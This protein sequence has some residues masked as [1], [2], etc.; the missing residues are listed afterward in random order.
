MKDFTLNDFHRFGLWTDPTALL[1][2]ENVQDGA[3]RLASHKT[4][5]IPGTT[6]VFVSFD[7]LQPIV[8][9]IYRVSQ[10]PVTL[11]EDETRM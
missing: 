9:T 10:V 7:R 5:T 8:H 2:A 6:C 4:K 3:T 11:V 1:D